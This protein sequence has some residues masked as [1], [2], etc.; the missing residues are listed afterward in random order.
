MTVNP[1]ELDFGNLDDLVELLKDAG[2][3]SVDT[4]ESKINAPGVWIRLD[5]IRQTQLTGLTLGLTLFLV[6]GDT[7]KRRALKGLQ[8]LWNEVIPVLAAIGGPTGPT[9]RA[10][11]ILPGST[12]PLPAL[13]VPLDLLTI[14]E[15]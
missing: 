2:I 13:A 5:T 10:G 8:D 4:D 11:L 7:D 14:N 9:T 12:T 6:V 1:S 15:E 3:R